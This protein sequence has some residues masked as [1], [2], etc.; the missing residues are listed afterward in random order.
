MI[1]AQLGSYRVEELIGEGGMSRVYRAQ[2]VVLQKNV[3]L[4]VLA[5]ELFDDE[6]FRERFLRESRMAA[7]L[8]HPNVIEI[9]DAGESDGR[10]YIAMRFI[11]GS[12]LQKLIRDGPLPPDRALAIL[13]QAARAL[14]AAH[15]CG[16]VHRDVKPANILLGRDD[17]VFLSDFG[18]AKFS[19]DGQGLTRTGYFVGTLEYAAPEQIR[20]E[21]LDGRADVY[22]FGCLL[23]QALSGELPYLRDSAVQLIFAHLEAPPPTLSNAGFPPALDGV[24]AKALAKRREDRYGTCTE[25]VDAAR[26][27]LAGVA[28]APTKPAA[29]RGVI[30][31]TA[32]RQVRKLGLA[33]R[34]R[35]RMI[36][37]ALVA[38]T[39]LSGA[40]LAVIL[41]GGSENVIAR[42]SGVAVD[43]RTGRPV[44]GVTVSVGD[45]IQT[46]APDGRFAFS[47]IVEGETIAVRGC[48]YRSAEARATAGP[49]RVEL[50]PEPVR[51]KVTS[52][53]T[54]RPVRAIIAGRTARARA[55][56]DGRFTLYGSCPGRK[57]RI[58]APGHR[59][60]SA[61][62]GAR[63][64][65]A[66]AL[67]ALGVSD[68][69][70]SPGLLAESRTE[71]AEKYRA[72]GAYHIVVRRSRWQALQLTRAG[73]VLRDTGVMVDARLVRG[74][75][76]S[77]FGVVCRWLD[78]THYYLFE[79]S[80]EG[81]FR[82]QKRDGG[83]LRTLRDW[84]PSPAIREGK[85]N[86]IGAT[87][88]GRRPVKLSL[89]VNASSVPIAVVEDRD[90]IGAGRVG[91]VAASYSR[92]E[93]H[94]V[95]DNLLVRRF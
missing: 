19:A 8:D 45:Q 21:E 72:Q 2:H 52:D 86:R 12:D 41:L 57:I 70:A 89:F 22:A 33:P 74:S 71:T 90:G 66:V 17:H 39:A 95:F 46:S 7:V 62:V 40:I 80:G 30:P 92:P 61:R 69:F 67:P 91:L 47:G 36:G 59:S 53:L 32:V 9:H 24:V 75:A 37:A 11:E 3:A 87:C 78:S 84:T 4:K 38:V 43:A 20:S 18:V 77:S 49:L 6:S 64:E 56:P 85:E 55:R 50:Q 73:V 48:A 25:L 31:T 76:E 42:V 35:R 16:L 1:G 68:G 26:T 94:V 10:L 88:S 28:V 34:W 63:R 54:G 51:G 81:F 14:D 44:G 27:A 93:T 13:G 15:E 82:M 79:I 23:Y 60:A 29:R 65:L 5:P 58:S 83:K